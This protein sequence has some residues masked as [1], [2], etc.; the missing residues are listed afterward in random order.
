MSA[1]LSEQLSMAARATTSESWG[2][3]KPRYR[4]ADAF[5]PGGACDVQLPNGL[6]RCVLILSSQDLNAD[7][8]NPRR[9]QHPSRL[10]LNTGKWVFA[11]LTAQLPIAR[12]ATASHHAASFSRQPRFA[13][14]HKYRVIFQ[15]GGL[16]S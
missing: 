3:V 11:Q 15:Y 12:T 13:A 2:M 9:I 10:V 14:W 6:L 16:M 8:G 4:G 5:H 1:Y 7:S